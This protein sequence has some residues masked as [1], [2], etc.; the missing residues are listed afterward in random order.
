MAV[1][2]WMHSLRSWTR[3]LYAA[4]RG[5]AGTIAAMKDA[6]FRILAENSMD[7]IVRVGPNLCTRYVSPAS[8]R[9][10][11]YV[12]E[13]LLGR[14]AHEFVLEEDLPAV[15][16]VSNLLAAGLADRVSAEFRVRAK[17]S[18]LV[19]MEGN[20]QRISTPEGGGDVVIVM[21]DVSERKKL[22]ESSPKDTRL[23]QLTGLMNGFVFEEELGR[24][25]RRA[26]RN[27]SKLSLLVVGIDHL[28]QYSNLYGRSAGNVAVS[29]VAEAIQ[30]VVQRSGDVV[31]RYGWE[32]LSVILPETDLDGA[33]SVGE[34]IRKEVRGA[35]IPYANHPDGKSCVTVTVGVASAQAI[36]SYLGYRMPGSLLV[37][38]DE[39]LRKA[40][41]GG[42]DAV[43]TAAV[44]GPDGKELSA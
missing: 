18:D 34:E 25:W 33:I 6:E 8:E 31:A 14:S 22:E 26:V 24:E 28:S 30:R 36:P 7:L 13:E 9:I 44:A 12:P 38:A 16:Q 17:S 37:A 15:V 39:A 43:Y 5:D 19:W 20:A 32:E 41:K 1:T 10:L 29:T 21:R 23:D 42:R 4:A 40:A 11:G 35:G 2:Q 27:G 3:I